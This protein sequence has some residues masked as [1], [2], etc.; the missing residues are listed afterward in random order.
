MKR[1]IKVWKTI[2]FCD[3][4]GKKTG[5]NGSHTWKPFHDSKFEMHFH[6]MVCYTE[7]SHAW[8]HTQGDDVIVAKSVCRI[9]RKN[10]TQ[11]K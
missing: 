10:L 1:R 6:S 3:W 11:A 2:L 7:F 5:E 4:C 8:I 9:N